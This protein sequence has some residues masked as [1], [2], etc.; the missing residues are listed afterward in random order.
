MNQKGK[1]VYFALVVSPLS[2][3]LWGKDHGVGEGYATPAKGKEFSL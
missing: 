1:M 2:L 3:V